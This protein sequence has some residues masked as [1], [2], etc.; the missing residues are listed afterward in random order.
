M[1]N[2]VVL[3]QFMEELSVGMAEWVCCHRPLDLV[4]TLAK[5]HLAA[6][7]GSQP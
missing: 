2:M 1:V 5:D 6:R 3:E 4:V 7:P